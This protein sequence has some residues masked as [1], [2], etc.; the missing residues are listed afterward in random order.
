[1]GSAKMIGNSTTSVPFN[2]DLS[3]VRHSVVVGPTKDGMTVFAEL[4]RQ[5]DVGHP[6]GCV[7]VAQADGD[8]QGE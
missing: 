8:G 7:S 5:W 1:M 6:G 3:E 2:F 4:V